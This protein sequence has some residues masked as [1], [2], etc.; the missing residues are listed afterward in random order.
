MIIIGEKINATRKKVGAAI[1][2][3]DRQVIIELVNQQA[4][5]GADYLDVNGGHPTRELEVVRWLL[6]IVQETT[7]LP[8]AL[9]SSSPQVILA[10]LKITKS[11]P[12]INSVSLENQRLD[13]YLP[14]IKDHDCSVIALLMSDQGVPTSVSDRKQRAET[15][16]GKLLDA[17]KKP[18]EIFVDP[19][20]LAI[21]T[22]PNA[23]NDVLETISYIRQR[24]EGIHV[25]G[26]LSNASYGLPKRKWLN[27]AYLMIAM[28][29]G[30]D[31]VIIDPCVEGTMSLVRAA[32]VIL[33]I[34]QMGMNYIE[35]DR[36]GKLD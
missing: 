4:Q 34:D 13:Q 36:A 32:Q 9:D 12:I 1:E 16:V 29:S 2:S 23:G 8:V 30:M 21:Y 3:Q 15:L 35:A 14:I 7:D 31:A 5:A 20:F 6:D 27:Q 26:G 28:A 22:E 11:K 25:A 33:G 18:Q 10:G 17:G 19:C 24:W